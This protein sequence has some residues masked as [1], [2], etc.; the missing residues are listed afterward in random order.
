LSEAGSRGTDDRRTRTRSAVGWG[1]VVGA[2]QAAS[3]LAIWWL[4]PATTY[5]VGLAAIAFVYIGLA[6][7]D[8]RSR[9][10]AVESVVAMASVVAACAAITGSPWVLVAGFAAHGIKDAWQ[11]RGQYVSG[12]RWWPPFCA[13]VDWVVAAVIAAEIAVGVRL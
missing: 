2:V 8:G 6:V 7:A 11:E 4:E 12:T 3:P 1:V 13:A 10:I 9:V 5:A